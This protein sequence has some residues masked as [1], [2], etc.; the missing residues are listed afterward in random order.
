LEEIEDTASSFRGRQVGIIEGEIEKEGARKKLHLS[1]I[2]Q[3]GGLWL[4]GK[5]GDLSPRRREKTPK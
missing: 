4:E 1:K 5:G 3:T 2:M